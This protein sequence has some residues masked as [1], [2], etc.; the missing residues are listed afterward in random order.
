MVNKLVVIFN[1][2][3]V[4]L[5]VIYNHYCII[6]DAQ[7][8]V[9]MS[10]CHF[11]KRLEV[12]LTLLDL[13][14]Y[15]SIRPLLLKCTQLYDYSGFNKLIF[16]FETKDLDGLRQSIHFILDEK[17]KKDDESL[18]PEEEKNQNVRQA[19]TALQSEKLFIE[20]QIADFQ[21]RYHKEVGKDLLKVAYYEQMRSAKKSYSTY[22]LK[23]IK[24]KRPQQTSS[25][26][27][28][29]TFEELLK[30]QFR[31]ASKLVHPDSAVI[32]F[33]D[34][35][36]K[37][38]ELNVYYKDKNLAKINELIEALEPYKNKKILDKTG[39]KRAQLELET[40]QLEEE[41]KRLENEIHFLKETPIFAILKTHEN[42]DDYF[43]QLKEDT[44]R[45]LQKVAGK[46]KKMVNV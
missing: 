43:I 31:K 13:G 42:I 5:V 24:K 27:N 45:K 33:K 3:V 39:I 41:K 18:R 9:I 34:A 38:N 44:Q 37:F 17:Y 22:D 28:R 8:S 30:A 2:F 11:K 19:L 12:I 35:N 16:Q 14:D 1:N 4:L 15:E 46:H 36:S 26:M 25:K 40:K 21:K 10:L 20:N 23:S 6:G 7:G 29:D 32:S